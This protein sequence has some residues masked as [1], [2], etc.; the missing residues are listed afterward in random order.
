MNKFYKFKSKSANIALS[1]FCI[2]TVMIIIILKQ[3]FAASI[4]FLLWIDFNL[5]CF[6]NDKFK[7]RKS[8][9]L[10]VVDKL[11]GLSYILVFDFTL[12]YYAYIK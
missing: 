7:L 6:L 4:F 12:Y 5:K 3:Y 2:F 9:L 8:A 1:I 10:K 11:I